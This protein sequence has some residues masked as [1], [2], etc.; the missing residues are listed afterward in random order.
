MK[1]KL[2][3]IYVLKI[4]TPTFNAG[5][6]FIFAKTVETEKAIGVTRYHKFIPKNPKLHQRHP[7][8]SEFYAPIDPMTGKLVVYYWFSKKWFTNK[9]TV[10][11]PDWW[12]KKYNF[13]LLEEVV[14]QDGV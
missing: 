9:D 14:K 8:Y 5:D 2:N 13:D 10:Q 7:T 3:K 1:L 4:G 12:V 6:E 11:L